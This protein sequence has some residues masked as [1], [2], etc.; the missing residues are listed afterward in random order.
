MAA[1]NSHLSPRGIGVVRPAQANFTTNC[2]FLA[3]MMFCGALDT[4]APCGVVSYCFL[5]KSEEEKEQRRV[6]VLV[7][8]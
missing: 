1:Q 2:L 6:R 7:R 5:L 3:V 4:K 8:G